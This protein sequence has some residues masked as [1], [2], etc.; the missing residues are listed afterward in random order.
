MVAQNVPNMLKEE[1]SSGFECDTFLTW[2]KNDHLREPIDKHKDT[3]VTI[4]CGGKI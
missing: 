4:I 2:H 3:I 1:L